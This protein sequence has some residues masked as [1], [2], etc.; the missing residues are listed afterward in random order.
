V[1][2][3]DLEDVL[4]EVFTRALARVSSFDAVG[5]SRYVS[6]LYAV[7]RNLITD[8]RRERA[9]TPET[10]ELDAAHDLPDRELPDPEL[11]LLHQE[12]LGTIRKAMERLGPSD[13]M[14]ITLSYDREMTCREIMEVME[15]PSVSAVTTHLYKAIKRLREQVRRLE[16]RASYRAGTGV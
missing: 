16:S 8:R 4:A 5:G 12:Q 6:Y 10:L 13:R 1:R 3:A 14:I 11:V 2:E 7:A 9:R 15:K